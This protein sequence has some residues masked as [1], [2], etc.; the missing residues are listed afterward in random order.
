MPQ[1]FPYGGVQRGRWLGVEHLDRARLLVLVEDLRCQERAH[2]R[3]DA[4]SGIS[5]DLHRL[6][7]PGDR[8]PV[9]AIDRHVGAE[10]QFVGWHGDAESR[11]TRKQLRKPDP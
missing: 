2:A 1:R 6:R 10:W 7:C 5:S 3:S 4:P 9:H 8:E 11:K